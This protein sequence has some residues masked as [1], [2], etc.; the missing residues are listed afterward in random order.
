M[1]YTFQWEIDKDMQNTCFICSR[2]SY[3]FERH[4]GVS[5][6]IHIAWAGCLNIVKLLVMIH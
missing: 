3:D 6:D 5:S 1:L 2:E 4:G